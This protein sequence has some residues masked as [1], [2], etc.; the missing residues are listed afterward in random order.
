MAWILQWKITQDLPLVPSLKS[1]FQLKVRLKDV[2]VRKLQRSSR[3]NPGVCSKI[4]ISPREKTDS[5]HELPFIW[6]PLI[7]SRG[8][9]TAVKAYWWASAARQCSEG[10]RVYCRL[11]NIDGL[12]NWTRPR[13]SL[14]LT[15][16]QLQ[17]W[18]LNGAT[19]HLLM[20][21][22]KRIQ[23][24]LNKSSFIVNKPDGWWFRDD[25]SIRQ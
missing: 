14:S 3:K 25:L 4:I 5:P 9:C 21:F 20:H 6:F 8:D 2:L 13:V 15:S 23:K 12:M 16:H 10:G 22:S 18:K 7:P 17:G 1:N 19:L 11:G 24:N